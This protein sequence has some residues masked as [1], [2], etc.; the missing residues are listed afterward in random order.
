MAFTHWLWSKQVFL[1]H[2]KNMEK[3]LG[4]KS[5][6][7]IFGDND[8]I[9]MVVM[10]ALIFVKITVDA[11]SM[12]SRDISDGVGADRWLPFVEQY[13]SFVFIII[14]IPFIMWAV[15]R[16]PLNTRSWAKGA[17]YHF[18]FSVI[19][20]IIHVA[21]FIVL[22]KAILYLLGG[23]YDYDGWPK[24]ALL[25]YPLDMATYL[26]IAVSYLIMTQL[27]GSKTEDEQ[28]V[29][30]N[31]G[32]RTLWIKPSEIIYVK[33]AGNYVDVV[34]SDK[35][36]LVRST[37]EGFQSL[38]NKKDGD[39][40]RVHRSTLANPSQIRERTTAKN[41]SRKLIMSNGDEITMSRRYSKALNNTVD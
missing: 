27:P 4:P 8:R 28:A 25:E 33:A 19:F 7:I 14:A 1:P 40:R 21:G 17:V 23:R 3:R 29:E 37:M 38:V 11:F 24:S 32:S 39:L 13:T 5:A 6:F 10:T 26:I 9:F 2:N 41:G 35:T 30:L 34:L 18:L 20:F 36:H 31:C 15:C 16:Y 22:R 12:Y